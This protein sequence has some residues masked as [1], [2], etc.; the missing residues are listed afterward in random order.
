LNGINKKVP[1]QFTQ[2]LFL[3]SVNR[4]NLSILLRL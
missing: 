1:E 3:L 4:I 2:G